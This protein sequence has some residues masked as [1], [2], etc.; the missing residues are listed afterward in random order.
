MWNT[1]VCL[2]RTPPHGIKLIQ[3]SYCISV[4]PGD[5]AQEDKV[6]PSIMQAS[7]TSTQRINRCKTRVVALGVC[8]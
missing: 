4:K 3:P 1:Q 7:D 6:R 2:I 5:Q 8:R